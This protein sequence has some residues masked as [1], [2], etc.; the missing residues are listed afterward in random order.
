MQK[1][2]P[3]RCHKPKVQGSTAILTR[4]NEETM[5]VAY[6]LEQRGLHATVAQS[7]G[8]F[9]F[10]NLAE[11]R[12]FIKQIGKVNEVTISKEKWQEAKKSTLKT[13]ASSTCLGIMRHFFA[14]F[15]AI[16]RIY[17]RSDL[18]EFVFESNIEDFI[19]SD[20]KSVFVSTIHKVHR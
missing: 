20:D 5:Q 9:R 8:G 13:Y 16:H 15:E 2:A 11:V 10:G 6:E 18:Q 4:T 17:Y 3:D 7:M 14:D 1:A 19:A 12:Y